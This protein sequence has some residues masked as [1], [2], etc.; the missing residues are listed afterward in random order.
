MGG[1][2]LKTPECCLMMHSVTKIKDCMMMTMEASVL[3]D[4]DARAIAQTRVIL[5]AGESTPLI[6]HPFLYNT[7]CYLS[8]VIGGR[9]H[10][11]TV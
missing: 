4:Q 5:L 1:V 3:R 2:Y 7:Q 9:S 10:R 6:M 8:S 11:P